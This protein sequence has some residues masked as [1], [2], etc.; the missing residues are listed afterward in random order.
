MRQ[1]R[2]FYRKQTRSFYVQLDDRQIN[3][4]PDEAD[5]YRRWHLL[6]AGA[7]EAVITAMN[8]P[9]KPIDTPQVATVQ[10][11]VKSYLGWQ[12]SQSKLAPALETMVQGAS[13]IVRGCSG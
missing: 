12:D 11:L 3:L 8:Q 13:E 6:M 5:A 10:Q 2:P 9:A 7:D 1:P 4:G